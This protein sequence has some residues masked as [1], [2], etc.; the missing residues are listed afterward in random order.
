MAG[1]RAFPGRL[2]AEQACAAGRDGGCSTGSSSFHGM[3][4]WVREPT[5]AQARPPSRIG[6]VSQPAAPEEPCLAARLGEHDALNQLGQSGATSPSLPAVSTDPLRA[7]PGGALC[8]PLTCQS[9][10][11]HPTLAGK[12]RQQ[13]CRFGES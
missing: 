1:G 13:Q 6:S 7:A 2:C 8:L 3:C 5:A 4:H 9:F 10:S 11:W 12:G